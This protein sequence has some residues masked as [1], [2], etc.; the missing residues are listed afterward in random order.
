LIKVLLQRSYLSVHSHS[1]DLSNATDR[2]PLALQLRVISRI[3]G[4]ERAKAWA[5]ILVGYEYNSKG[6]PAVKYNCGQPMGAYSSWPT[7]ALTHHL[8]VRVA[9]LRADFPHFTSYCL[10][11][12]DIVIANDACGAISFLVIFTGYAHFGA[13]THVSND[14]FEFAKRWF[15]KGEEVTGFSIAVSVMFGRFIHFCTITYPHSMAMVGSLRLRRT[16]T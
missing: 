5:H 7:T 2:M 16:G 12:D 1:L 3:I 8:I 14:T 9:G 11:G 6:G 4:E 15:H 13:K 10:L